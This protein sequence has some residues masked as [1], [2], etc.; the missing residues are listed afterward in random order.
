MVPDIGAFRSGDVLKGLQTMPAGSFLAHL[1]PES[2]PLLVGFWGPVSRVYQRDEHLPGGP[3]GTDV[4]IVL[5]GCVRQ[6]RFPF[7]RR[8]DDPV[9]SRFRGPGQLLGEAELI[10]SGAA[11]TTTC[12][13]T[14]WV[15]SGSA[16]R[17][18]AFLDRHPHARLA[19]LRSLETRNRDDEKIY[20]TVTRTPLHRVGGLLAHLA[21]TAGTADPAE[22]GHLTVLGLSQKD[23]AEALLLGVSTVE[24]AVR[25]LRTPAKDSGLPPGGVLR[26]RYRQ[27]VVTDLPALHRV[28]GVE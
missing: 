25:G 8:D 11:V 16:Q 27:F 24:S 26:S 18:N 20:G 22:P 21:R 12:L 19:L 9:I 7:G 6:D 23:I 1:P 13:T 15:M 5:G 17:M 3:D 28:T 14:T 2:W 4:H 10:A